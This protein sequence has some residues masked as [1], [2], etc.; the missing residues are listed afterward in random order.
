MKRVAII[1]SGV[2]GISLSIRLAKQ[3]YKIDVYESNSYPGGK[4]TSIKSG[5]YS[6]DAGPR[7]FTMPHYVDELF[8]LHNEDPRKYF[9]YKKK[10]Y[11]M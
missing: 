11:W 4:L 2:A 8:E 1:G 6:F 9:N 10:R 5:K 3:G 7:L